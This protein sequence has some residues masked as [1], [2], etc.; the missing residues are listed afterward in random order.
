MR[1]MRSSLMSRAAPS[2]D[3]GGRG[4]AGHGLRRAGL[5]ELGT[6]GA[7]GQPRDV[8][9]ARRAFA[10][11]DR[12]HLRG[13]ERGGAVNPIRTATVL[14]HRRPAETAPAIAELRELARANGT[15]LRFNPE[16]TRK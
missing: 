3:R 7:E 11:R 14:T 2:P 8:H 16:E 15:V 10:S 13:G 5:R 4:S 12:R 1:S 9:L 6:S